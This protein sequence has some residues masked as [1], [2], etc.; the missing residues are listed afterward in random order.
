MVK[1]PKEEM[2]YEKVTHWGKIFMYN[3]PSWNTLFPIV[4][5]IRI[6][7]KN[8]IIT[9]AYAKNQ[10]SIK[11]YA[12]QYNHMVYGIDLETV[13]DYA[14]NMQNMKYI[15]TFSDGQD[16]IIKNVLNYGS[17]MKICCIC[18]SMIDSM[19]H[20]YDY[21]GEEMEKYTFS[22][23]LEVVEKMEYLKE[24]KKLNTIAKLF[25]DFE[26]IPQEKVEVNTLEQCLEKL[27]LSTNQIK[28]KKE[29]E[30]IH[31]LPFDANFSQLKHMERAKKREVYDDEPKPPPS[32]KSVLS[33][34]FSKPKKKS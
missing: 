25:P 14:K 31:K 18:F 29:K 6:L 23:P 17:K 32:A 12:S 13:D 15:F 16:S 34:F 10:V 9:H 7:P 22:K 24:M 19:Y 2:I 30:V 1:Q 28:Q 33:A 20:F 4:D 26:I 8:T 21:T 11:T 27:R 5:I 3:S